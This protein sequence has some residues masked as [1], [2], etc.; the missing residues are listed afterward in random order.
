MTPRPPIG[1]LTPRAI[2]WSI[3]AGLA[4]VPTLLLALGPWLLTGREVL[5]FDTVDVLYR[6]VADRVARGQLPYRDFLFE[7]PIGCLPQILIPRLAGGGLPA[8]RIAYIAEMLLANALLILALAREVA[9]R[10]GPAAVP[11][12]LGW[13]LLGY[14]FL[15]R[16][17][18]SRIDVVPALLAFLAA[19]EW[20]AGR[21]VRGGVLAAIGGLVKLFPALAVLPAGLGEFSLDRERGPRPRGALTFAIVFAAGL[22]AWGVVGGAGMLDAIAFHA[23]RGLE[24]ESTGAGLLML[25]GRL[26][27][28]PMAIETGHGSV[29]VDAAWAP[30]VVSVSRSIQLVAL[31][32]TMIPFALAHRRS[33]LQCT[34]ALILAVIATAPVL[35][36]Q[37]LIWVL[38]FVMAAG[39]PAG[40]RA[41]PL[42]VLACALTFLIY[43][44]LFV[45]ALMP[46]RWPAL[47]VLN[48]RNAIVVVLWF[49]LTFGAH[50]DRGAIPVDVDDRRAGL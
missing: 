39:G 27:G 8:Y 45:P 31:A 25:A 23:E 50:E 19:A 40:R 17:I 36:P 42:F 20:S 46:M 11:R 48:F 24:I 38:P 28:A 10:E 29:D 21:A 12:R 49:V 16:L 43:P 5:E 26:A 32:S 33:I 7:Y 47:L 35:S 30:A 34:G 9:R 14:L 1:T 4:C 22:A 18:V 13:Y 3:A 6:D 37:F 44:V 2:A 15:C 41:R